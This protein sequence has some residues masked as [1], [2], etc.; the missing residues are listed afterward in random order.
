M[1]ISKISKVIDAIYAWHDGRC[2]LSHIADYLGEDYRDFY[3]FM[4]VNELGDIRG[5]PEETVTPEHT[6][7]CLTLFLVYRRAKPTYFK[8]KTTGWR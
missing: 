5:E 7:Y 4:Y 8:A 1:D 3:N 2:N 6:I